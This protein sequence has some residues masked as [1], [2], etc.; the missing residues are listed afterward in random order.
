M[1][2]NIDN[3]HWVLIVLYPAQ[4]K[5]CCYDSMHDKHEKTGY[6]NLTMGYMTT[7]RTFLS[8]MDIREDPMNI[9]NAELIYVTN[10][11]TQKNGCDCGVFTMINAD[12]ILDDLI[13]TKGVVR[14]NLYDSDMIDSFREIIACHILRGYINY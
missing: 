10:I 13:D 8:H 1:P 3:I 9:R 11:P 12:Y 5:M 14:P 6:M 4:N 2:V 7:I